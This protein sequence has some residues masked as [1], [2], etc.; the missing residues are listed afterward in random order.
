MT[1]NW[2]GWFTWIR[3]AF[4]KIFTTCLAKM[5]RLPFLTELTY[6]PLN[7]TIVLFY[8]ANKNKLSLK[9]NSIFG[10]TSFW[11]AH[12]F[13]RQGKMKAVD[14]MYINV[15]HPYPKRKPIEDR[16]FYNFPGGQTQSTFWGR[17]FRP[18]MS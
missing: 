14:A 3:M 2:R 18:G 16:L 15:R 8:L 11:S 12:S 7:C 1:Y 5:V 10:V 13:K 17:Y 6:T 4:L 9:R